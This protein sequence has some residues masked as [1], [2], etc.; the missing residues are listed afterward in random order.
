MRVVVQTSRGWVNRRT[1]WKQHEP[2]RVSQKL[3]ELCQVVEYFPALHLRHSVWSGLRSM[4]GHQGNTKMGSEI[5]TCSLVES[6]FPNPYP[7]PS[8]GFGDKFHD[9]SSTWV[10][11]PSRN[12]PPLVGAHW[13]RQPAAESLLTCCKTSPGKVAFIGAVGLGIVDGWPSIENNLTVPELSPGFTWDVGAKNQEQPL[14]LLADDQKGR[15]RWVQHG[16]TMQLHF[17]RLEALA[18]NNPDSDACRR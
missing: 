13:S 18:E 15:F 7:C 5:S 1:S 17:G 6:T 16:S 11:T 10:L 8:T 14:P 2:P 9:G 12:P 4:G 3:T